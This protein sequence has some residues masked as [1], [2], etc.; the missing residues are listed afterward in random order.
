MDIEYGFTTSLLSQEDG[1]GYFLEVPALP[2]CFATAATLEEALE[3]LKDA[4]ATWK[5]NAKQF[6]IAIPQPTTKS[7]ELPSGRFSVRIPRHIHQEL[8]YIAEQE[9]QSLNMIVGTY[10][11]QAV[12][13]D[14]IAKSVDKVCGKMRE[15]FDHHLVSFK[16]AFD[17]SSGSGKK[18]VQT[19]KW[20][21]SKIGLPN[22][23]DAA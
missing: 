18:L 11:A 1:G 4:I 15:E 13:G 12:S 20:D 14:L 6:D 10:L 2:G 8:L 17:W 7:T 9:N 23:Q 21:V 19:V 22:Y 5:I 3:K 16:E